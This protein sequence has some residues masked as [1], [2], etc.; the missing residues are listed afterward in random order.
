MPLGFATV[1]HW[2]AVARE[3]ISK[4]RTKTMHTVKTTFI[5][6]FS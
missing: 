3:L 4:D 5:T 1:G 6:E 2:A